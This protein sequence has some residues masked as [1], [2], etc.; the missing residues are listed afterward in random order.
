MSDITYELPPIQRVDIRPSETVSALAAQE[1]WA[2]KYLGIP[3][4]WRELGGKGVTVAV[5]DTGIDSTHPA[6]S[7][8]VIT[9]NFTS[10][11]GITRDVQGHGTHCAGSIAGRGPY[12]GIATKCSLVIGKIL[13]DQGRGNDSWMAAGIRWASNVG[14]NIISIS[15]GGPQKSKIVGD[16]LAYAMSLESPPLI[17]VSA[18]NSGDQGV[19]WPGASSLVIGVAAHDQTGKIAGFSS[20]GPEVDIAAPGVDILAPVPGGGYARMSGTSMACPIVAGV[21]ALAFAVFKERYGRLPQVPEVM[22]MLKD[23]A[24][25]VGAPGH[26][27]ESGYGIIDVRMIRERIELADPAKPVEPPKPE[28]P[29]VERP[30]FVV[31]DY[32]RLERIGSRISRVADLSDDRKVMVLVYEDAQGKFVCDDMHY[33]NAWLFEKVADRAAGI[34][35]V[36]GMD[37]DHPQEQYHYSLGDAYLGVGALEKVEPSLSPAKFREVI[38]PEAIK[39]AIHFARSESPNL[40]Q[41]MQYVPLDKGAKKADN[42]NDDDGDDRDDNSVTFAEIIANHG[43]CLDEQRYQIQEHAKT[44]H[45][46]ARQLSAIEERLRSQPDYATLAGDVARIDQGLKILEREA[47]RRGQEVRQDN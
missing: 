43:Q 30:P 32:V 42:L 41:Y 10:L 25:D 13:D 37:M 5:L 7:L 36:G 14:A 40:R 38:S 3:E 21:A 17:C 24:R 19:T 33:E 16:A 31:G 34:D 46:L 22:K 44:I 12:Y 35:P 18:G 2:A 23:L 28:P 15:A 8:G 39:Q 27:R 45:S 47:A 11:S 20:R 4:D 1:S 9:Y 6:L 26:D 29:K